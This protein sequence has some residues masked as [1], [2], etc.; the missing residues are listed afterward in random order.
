MS[1]DYCMSPT[2]KWSFVKSGQ[3]GQRIKSYLGITS[4]DTSGHHRVVLLLL[5]NLNSL[6]RQIFKRP[7]R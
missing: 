2:I 7:L 1:L 3:V 4:L 5:S 6:R